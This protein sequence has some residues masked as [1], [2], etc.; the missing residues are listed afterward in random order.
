[1]R[2]LKWDPNERISPL[3]AL[4]HSWV[5]KGLPSELRVKLSHGYEELSK[6]QPKKELSATKKNGQSK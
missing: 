3:E 1:M 6:S 4:N 5:S 2:F